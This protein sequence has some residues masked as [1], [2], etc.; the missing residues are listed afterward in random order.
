MQGKTSAKDSVF[1]GVSLNDH[2]KP[3]FSPLVLRSKVTEITPSTLIAINFFFFVNS[4]LNIVRTY[5]NRKIY[6]LFGGLE[7]SY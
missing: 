7:S 6:S 1:L 4:R 5:A 2:V 3:N